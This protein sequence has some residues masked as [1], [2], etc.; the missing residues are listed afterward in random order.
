[1]QAYLAGNPVLPLDFFEKNVVF[2]CAPPEIFQP[3]ITIA[4]RNEILA[5]G[6]PA[7]S[8]PTGGRGI[9]IR[10]NSGNLISGRNTDMANVDRPNG[11]GRS[12]QRF[13]QHWLHGDL[14]DMAYFYNFKCFEATVSQGE[15]K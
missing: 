2:R 15:L 3:A 6:I 4:A 9:S 1:M 7:L 5:K 14:K 12:H 11:W 8:G 13:L 10:D